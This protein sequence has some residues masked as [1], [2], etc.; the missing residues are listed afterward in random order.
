M[1]WLAAHYKKKLSKKQIESIDVREIVNLL[2]GD[3]NGI[4]ISLRITAD[5][6]YGLCF[7]TNEQLKYMVFEANRKLDDMQ[8]FVNDFSKPS[9][10][11]RSIDL[12]DDEVEVPIREMD[13]EAI[14]RID[15][16]L[17]GLPEDIFETTAGPQP[18]DLSAMRRLVT[19]PE[20]IE[21]P[22]FESILPHTVDD[23]QGDP[24]L[25]MEEFN[26]SRQPSVAG[27]PTDQQNEDD[28]MPPIEDT[29]IYPPE[30]DMLLPPTGGN[31]PREPLSPVMMMPPRPDSPGIIL[32]VIDPNDPDIQPGRARGRRPAFRVDG[33]PIAPRPPQRP[34]L[35]RTDVQIHILPAVMRA[36]MNLTFDTVPAFAPDG[37]IPIIDHFAGPLRSLPTQ[38]N[39]LFARVSDQALQDVE[40]QVA[41]P[42][43]E[44]QD[45]EP[46]NQPS[47]P[48]QDDLIDQP[49]PDFPFQPS[50]PVIPQDN[51]IFD[52]EPAQQQE[53]DI[54]QGRRG[55]RSIDTD[56]VLP[57]D[58]D[59]EAERTFGDEYRRLVANIPE[60][61]IEF[62][63]FI[64]RNR[65][66]K[67]V[68][69]MFVNLLA[70][71][72][73]GEVELTQAP[74]YLSF[75]TIFVRRLDVISQEI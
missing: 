17:D 19:L 38:L 63:Q 23:F 25:S 26:E 29:N 20:P 56:F 52:Q 61:Q 45:H 54:S 50:P 57:D 71:K 44:A 72:D 51:D 24:G 66:R 34:R 22:N 1:V 30:I 11:R 68:A 31:I 64:G 16:L 6:M 55:T 39:Y 62:D 8:K 9:G 21:T 33:S 40:A 73:A 74:S 49:I 15:Q 70:S 13:L 28:Q 3:D 35:N 14:H 12:R 65:K 5:L 36:G 42:E 69:R 58:D 41:Q 4:K 32:P 59:A 46:P 47:P 27:Q 37:L 67:N 53:P 48:P 7:I 60:Q 18:K 10:P 2:I 75:N 43:P